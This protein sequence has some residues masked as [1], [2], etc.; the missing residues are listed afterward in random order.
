MS[1]VH[2]RHGFHAGNFADVFKHALLCALLDALNRKPAPW[3]YLETHSGAG[4]YDLREEALRT[5]EFRDGI[6]RI[7]T[8]SDIP[9]AMQAYMRIVRGLGENAY[10]GSP[11]V[12][13]AF[14]R[15]GDRLALC[16]KIPEVAESLKVAI[17]RDRRVAVHARDGYEAYALLPPT[18]KRGLVLV[19]PAFERRDEFDA[20]SEF[21]QRSLARFA[22]GLYVVWYPLKNRHE[23]NKFLRRQERELRRP[24]I[25]VEL[26]TGAP[27]EGQMRGCGILVVNPPFGFDTQARAMLPFLSRRL[28]QGPKPQ[29]LLQALTPSP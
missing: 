7:R 29:W 28:A 17:G 14:A 13:Q 2:Y 9:A 24:A 11:L 6:E 4:R 19:D 20:V 10:P 5:G 25:H 21:L 1:V 26:E 12:A 3:F 16:E 8:R 15:E 22:N 27:A 18:E 23:A